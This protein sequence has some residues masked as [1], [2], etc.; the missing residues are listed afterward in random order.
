MTPAEGIDEVTETY[1]RVAVAYSEQVYGLSA[2]SALDVALI[3]G[4]AARV[5]EGGG[6]PVA[7]VGCGPGRMSAYLQSLGIDSFGVDLSP[8]MI[9]VARELYPEIS[10]SVG[11]LHRL[12]V[13]DEALAGVLAWYSIIHTPVDELDAVFT[14]FRRVLRPGGYLLLGLHVGSGVLRISQSYGHDVG[15]DLHLFCPDGIAELLDDAGFDVLA[16][17]VREPER[18]E[19][20]PQAFLLA[21]KQSR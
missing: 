11:S 1:N 14:E 2:E 6:G 10:F 13:G 15:V 4:F 3:D 19:R 16:T 7:D 5:I 8:G 9:E 18:R 17:L 20:R 12:E 21:Q